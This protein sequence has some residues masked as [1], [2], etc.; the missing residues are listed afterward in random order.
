MRGGSGLRVHRDGAPSRESRGCRAGRNGVTDL[1]VAAAV[2]PAAVP[3]AV[4]AGLACAHPRSPLFV[5]SKMGQGLRPLVP[6]LRTL[7]GVDISAPARHGY[8]NP[9]TSARHTLPE[10]WLCVRAL[11]PATIGSRR[12]S[13]VAW[14]GCTVAT[15]TALTQ[16][17]VLL[18]QN[19]IDAYLEANSEQ[20]RRL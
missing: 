14:P 6:K 13:E 19:G 20:S 17:H 5:Q 11:S 18:D 15:S 1:L 10:L 16:H 7:S 2:A 4:A 8:N 9:R 12:P 3:P